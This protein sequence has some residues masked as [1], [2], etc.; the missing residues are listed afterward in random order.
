MSIHFLLAMSAVDII[1]LAELVCTQR[2]LA[3]AC[4]NGLIGFNSSDGQIVI[5]AF[6]Q[7]HLEGRRPPLLH[8]QG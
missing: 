3:Y 2:K 5:F 7:S 1:Q 6:H 4:R 8:T